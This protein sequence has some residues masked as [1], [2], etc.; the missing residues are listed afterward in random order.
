MPQRFVVLPLAH[1]LTSQEY[2]DSG[3]PVDEVEKLTKEYGI[4]HLAIVPPNLSC[5]RTQA[6]L[7]NLGSL[8]FVYLSSPPQGKK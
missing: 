5:E 3:V 6:P 7:A 2:H 1:V 4:E 8:K